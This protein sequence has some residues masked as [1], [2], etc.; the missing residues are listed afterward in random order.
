MFETHLTVAGKVLT[1]LTRH[2]FP[3]G[4]EK[5]SFRLGARERRFDRD[6]QEWGDGDQV[7]LTVN[8]WR[9]VAEGV[10]LSLAKGDNVV[11][12]GRYFVREYTAPNGERRISNELDARAIGPDLAWCSVVVERPGGL[13]AVSTGTSA[14]EVVAA[15]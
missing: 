1:E 3:S 8:C 10:R 11:V 2:T 14:E 6:R 5:M 7:V 12:M 15:A 13:T 4:G 9:R